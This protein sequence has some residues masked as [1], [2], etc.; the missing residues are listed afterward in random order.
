MCANK[1]MSCVLRHRAARR[2][3]I[4]QS[5][6]S[7][8]AKHTPQ[9]RIV[10]SHDPEYRHTDTAAAAAAAAVAALV[11]VVE[12]RAGGGGGGGGSAPWSTDLLGSQIV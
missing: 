12:E 8:H 3:V 4:D 6:A 10:L 7:I 11:T 2:A 9:L 1:G 5:K